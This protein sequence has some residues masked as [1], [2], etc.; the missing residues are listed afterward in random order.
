MTYDKTP[1]QNARHLRYNQNE[2]LRLSSK[3]G[4]NY[5]V[6]DVKPVEIINDT[7]DELYQE[8]IERIQE[9]RGA[10]L[11]LDM[12]N[13]KIVDSSGLA[14]LVKAS[15]TYTEDNGVKLRLLKTSD[16]VK[17]LIHIPRLDEF[18]EVDEE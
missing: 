4:L 12:T 14:K 8:L 15:K 10:Y 13:V 1:I 6:F 7:S 2:S 9:N 3:S 16:Y 11:A 18:M 5:R 17:E